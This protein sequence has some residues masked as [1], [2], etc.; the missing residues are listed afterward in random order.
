[1]KLYERP[2]TPKRERP[3]S[4]NENYNTRLNNEDQTKSS[5]AFNTVNGSKPGSRRS[6]I[7]QLILTNSVNDEENELFLNQATELDEKFYLDGSCSKPPTPPPKVEIFVK[8]F[9]QHHEELEDIEG[10]DSEDETESQQH[11]QA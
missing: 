4:S 2:S 8:K 7:E 9:P 1:M 11:H 10:S 3:R 6:S 5:Y